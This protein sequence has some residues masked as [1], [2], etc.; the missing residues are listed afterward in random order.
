MVRTLYFRIAL[1]FV[2]TLVAIPFLS[3]SQNCINMHKDSI[4]VLAKTELPGFVFTKEI[5]NG[6]R[7]FI[8]FE[9]AFEEQTLIFMLNDQGICTSVSRMYNTWLFSQLKERLITQYG[10]SK[11]LVWQFTEDSQ[12]Y[13][14]ELIKGEWYLTVV[15][16]RQKKM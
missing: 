5:E 12:S 13:E 7:S 1:V 15:T 6:N 11:D 10:K 4:K 2:I 9:N 3:R 16:R 14:V 8:K